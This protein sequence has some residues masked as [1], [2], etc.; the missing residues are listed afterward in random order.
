[1]DARLAYVVACWPVLD[2]LRRYKMVKQKQ[3]EVHIQ[4][5]DAYWPDEASMAEGNPQL[6]LERGEY[7]ALPPT[8]LIQ[9]TGDKIVLPEMTERF[10]ATFRERGGAAAIEWYSGKPH[11][12]ITKEPDA[13]ESRAAIQTIIR[14][15]LEQA[16][17][18][19]AA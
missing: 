9:G 15:V 6:I 12:F 8:L 18:L 16:Q 3:M 2:P 10:A 7:E 5:H 17:H 19:A 14:F 1:M 4:S 11:T 13:P